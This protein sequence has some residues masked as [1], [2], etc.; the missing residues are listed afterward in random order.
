MGVGAFKIRGNKKLSGILEVEGS[1]NGSL[2]IFVATLIEKGTYILRNIPNLMDIRTLIK[3]LESL[4]LE[5]EQLDKHSY[6]IVNNGIKNIEASYELVKK[7]RASFLVMGPILAHCGEAKVSLPGGCAI[8]ARPVDLHLKG[9]E[10]LGTEITIEHG[11]VHGEVKDGKLKGDKI[12]LDFPSVGATENIIMAAV[13]AQGVTIIENVAREPE[14]DDLCHFLNKMGA[15]IEGIGEGKLIITGVDKL[16][17]CE[18]EIIPDRIVAGTFIIAAVMFEGVKV[19]GVRTEHLESF[20]M[21]LQEMGVT[22]HIDENGLFEVTSKLEDLKGVKV[23]TMPHPGFPTDL[24]SPIMTLMC[25]AKGSSEITET[26]FENRFMHVPE[27]NRMGAEITTEKNI[28]VIKGIDKFSS[29]QVMSS[30]LRA[31]A[32]LVLAAL[33]SEGE[34]T[35]NRIYHID[36]GYEDLEIKL[37]NIGADIERVK[38]EI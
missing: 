37:R 31:G 13:K 3:L 14:I 30:D 27:L 15:K 5:V 18:Y 34:S 32:A 24:Q 38:E 23:K 7:M 35:V 36:R 11:Y 9:F 29:A 22:Y 10:A 20:L 25:L 28:A 8:G 21:K 26:I 12:I 6:K 16:Y 2:P 4:G 17:P 33:K 19:K 1:K